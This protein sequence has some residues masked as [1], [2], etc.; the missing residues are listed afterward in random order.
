M[1]Y[2]SAR[3]GSF[4]VRH[5]QPFTAAEAGDATAGGNA[6]VQ[7]FMDPRRPYLGNVVDITA[8]D[9]IVSPPS[10]GWVLITSIPRIDMWN[11]TS[12]VH[13]A[14]TGYNAKTVVTSP[15]T[16]LATD[17]AII[18][19]LTLT[20]PFDIQLPTA[21]VINSQVRIKD[22]KGD[23]LTNAITITANG[24]FL[25]DGSSTLTLAQTYG[26]H[27]LLFDDTSMWRVM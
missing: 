27:I 11:G 3:L 4:H 9:A 1:A 20:G 26:T 13:P 22:G 6:N 25:I 7:Q 17:E 14:A 12:W 10:G 2:D 15:Y 24:G 18:C 23:S 8:R 5:L 19:N 21:P 16:V